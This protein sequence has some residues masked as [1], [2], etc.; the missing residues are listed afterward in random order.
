MSA[1][2]KV[3]II[4]GSGLEDPNILKNATERNVETIFGR[5]SDVVTEGLIGKVPCAILSRHGR[6]H[7]ILPS[8]VNYR[9]NIWALKELGCTHILATNACGG[10]QE[11]TQP[12]DIVILDQFF[13]RTQGREQTFYGSKGNSLKGVL[14]MPM[15][16]PFCEKTREVLADAACSLHLNVWDRKEGIPPADFHPCVHTSGSCVTIN[17]PRFSSRFES[18]LFKQWGSDVVNMTL[19]PEV[20]LAREVGISYASMAIVTDYDSW[21]ADGSEVCVEMVV[22]NFLKNVEKVKL[23]L[24]E[25]VRII[26]ER[27]WTETIAVNQ[28]LVQQSRQD[29]TPENGDRL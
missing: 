1:T 4:G 26:G 20:A 11:Y 6:N 10:L 24:K 3:G 16:D 15:G 8:E 27:D 14:H 12:G 18:R 19:V 17:G 23:I 2:V 13:D 28:K 29:K 5:P 9:A 7:S 25:A 21:K 22:Q